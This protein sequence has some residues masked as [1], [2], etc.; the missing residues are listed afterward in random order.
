MI[1]LYGGMSLR[2]VVGECLGTGWRISLPVCIVRCVALGKAV[3][4]YLLVC[5]GAG[6]PY[7][8]LPF[9]F[10]SVCS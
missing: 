5:D 7:L 6:F 10:T 9:Y 3:L 4:P 2:R 8:L 1:R